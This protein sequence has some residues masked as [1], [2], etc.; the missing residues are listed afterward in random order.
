MNYTIKYTIFLIVIPAFL[1]YFSCPAGSESSDQ[2]GI[3]DLIVTNTEKEVLI[4]LSLE[5]CFTRDMEEAIFAGITTTFVFTVELYRN[6]SLWFDKKE[7]VVEAR[8][9]IKYDSVRRIM[10]VAYSYKGLHREPEQFSEISRARRAMEE[11]NGLPL[12]SLEKLERGKPYYLHV[13]A[14]LERVPLPLDVKGTLTFTPQWYFETDWV[15][16]DFVY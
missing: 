12:I 11:L 13:R 14:K 3:A 4:Y 9:S 7:T 10:N 2:P 15:R 1:I 16:Q 8:H 6:R 5:N